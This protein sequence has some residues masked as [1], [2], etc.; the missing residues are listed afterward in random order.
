MSP[1]YN[2][3]MK[4]KIPFAPGEFYHIYNRGVDKRNIFLDHADYE[5][6]INLLFFCNGS[7]KVN[8]RELTK[9]LYKGESFVDLNSERGDSLVDIGAFCL[10]PTH[11]HLL[12]HE[13]TGEGISTFLRKLCTAYSMY[14]NTKY[15]RTGRLFERVFLARHTGFDQYLKYLF[16]YIHLNPAK[17]I[18]PAWKEKGIKNFSKI[19][20]FIEKYQYSS[21]RNYLGEK[22][23]QELLNRPVFPQYFSNPTTR[24]EIGEWL[25]YPALTKDS[26]L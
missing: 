9:R 20:S 17:I 2:L 24:T 13:R 10:M 19:K 22:E 1:L 26:P 21:Y 8:M 5:R 25:T 14:F 18:E 6:F 7:M 11:F 23:N 15:D 12:L 3:D 16:S 4:R